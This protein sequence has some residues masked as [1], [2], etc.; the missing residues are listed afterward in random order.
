M[1]PLQVLTLKTLTYT[2]CGW[3]HV[4]RQTCNTAGKNVRWC[5]HLGKK[6]GHSQKAN[7]VNIIWSFYSCVFIQEIWKHIFPQRYYMIALC[8]VFVVVSNWKQSKYSLTGEWINKLWNIHN[9]EY[10]LEKNKREL[11]TLPIMWMNLKI[12]MLSKSRQVRRYIV[13]NFI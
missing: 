3:E 13:Y 5:N 1:Y 4:V 12:Y 8:S 6:S 11:L 10:H 2:K 7:A 9:M